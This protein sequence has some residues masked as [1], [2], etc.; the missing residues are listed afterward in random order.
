MANFSCELRVGCTNG[1]AVE[2]TEVIRL[3]NHLRLTL[4]PVS[5]LV[6]ASCVIEVESWPSALLL[7]P[8]GVV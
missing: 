7:L 8:P 6:M 2:R 3:V 1:E 5:L 4:G